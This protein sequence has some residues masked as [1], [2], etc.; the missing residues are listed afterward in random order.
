MHYKQCLF[1]SATV[2]VES[3]HVFF[4][5]QK[6]ESLGPTDLKFLTYVTCAVKN[7]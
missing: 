5:G 7:N 6:K 3:L 2:G 1:T 4:V